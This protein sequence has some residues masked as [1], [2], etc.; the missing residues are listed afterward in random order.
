ME[1]EDGILV[2]TNPQDYQKWLDQKQ[3]AK[4]VKP[5]PKKKDK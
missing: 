2:F 4:K 1:K 3:E 5:A